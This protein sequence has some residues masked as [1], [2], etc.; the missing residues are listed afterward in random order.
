MA[1][2]NQTTITK[3]LFLAT[4]ITTTAS[5]SWGINN[6]LVISSSSEP[7]STKEE[8]QHDNNNIANNIDNNND[9]INNDNN[10][11]INNNINNHH[12]SSILRRAAAWWKTSQ[13]TFNPTTQIIVGDST[14]SDI[15]DNNINITG[16]QWEPGGP[17]MNTIFQANGN[18]NNLQCT[19]KEVELEATKVEGPDTC[20]QGTI[21]TVNIS[22]NVYFHATRYDLAFYTYTGNNTL[23][24]IFGESCAVDILGEDDQ[25]IGWEEGNEENGV[26]DMDGDVCYD[27]VGQSGWTLRL[28]FIFSFFCVGLFFDVIVRCVCI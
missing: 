15:T 18:N 17:C 3:W 1:I 24:P 13:P 20:E 23:D 10:N 16:P 8:Q 4:A 11:K 27:V 14:N 12:S 19:A 26:Y 21:I 7:P 25:I 28:V 2:I 9:K 6:N 22:A 5:W